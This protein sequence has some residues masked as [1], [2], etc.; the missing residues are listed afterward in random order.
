[1][2]KTN[3]GSIYADISIDGRGSE[4][5]VTKMPI[6][7]LM[8][9]VICEIELTGVKTARVRLSIGCLLFKLAAWITGMKGSI[10]VGN[11]VIGTIV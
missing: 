9:T 4:E 5:V 1:M 7:D 6:S 10:K 11:S 3:C 8:R 2:S